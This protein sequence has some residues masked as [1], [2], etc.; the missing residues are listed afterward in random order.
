MIEITLLC[1][2]PFVILFGRTGKLSY[3]FRGESKNKGFIDVPCTVY[4]STL[5]SC[6]KTSHS[7]MCLN[8]VIGPNSTESDWYGLVGFWTLEIRK[9]KVSLLFYYFCENNY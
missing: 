9:E 8:F 5:F 3:V 6:N 4:Y 1:N 7:F 2:Y